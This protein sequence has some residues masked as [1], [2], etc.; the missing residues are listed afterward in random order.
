MAEIM[1]YEKPGCINNTKQKQLL[2]QAGHTVKEKNLLT[3]S[4][5]TTTLR[6]FFGDKPVCEW[7]NRS[8]P[9]IKQGEVNPEQMHESAAL[10]AMIADPLLI[11]RP[12]MR[13]GDDQR[14]GFDA[15]QVDEW[16]GLQQI[17][18]EQDLEHCPRSHQPEDFK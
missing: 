5:Q 13:V 8:A 18:P 15:R 12:L 9:R 11:R 16:I 10:A 6:P 17:D 1:F 4:W 14:V 7:F 2:R 3:E